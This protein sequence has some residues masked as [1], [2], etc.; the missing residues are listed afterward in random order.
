M[1]IVQMVYQTDT[2]LDAVDKFYDEG[3]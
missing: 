1:S 2:I 3:F